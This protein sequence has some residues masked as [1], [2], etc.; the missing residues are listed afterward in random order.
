[1]DQEHENNLSPEEN[2]W[3]D[4]ILPPEDLGEELGPHESVEDAGLVS[5]DA[6][7]DGWDPE[8]KSR[9]TSEPFQDEE[10]RD[11]FGEGDELNAAFA[12]ENAPEEAPEAPAEEPE[13]PEEAPEEPV[14]KGRPRRKKGYGLL[15][16]PHILATF[17]WLAIAIAIGVSLGRVIW[18]CVSD[19]MAFGRSDTELEF[20]VTD[21]DT[22]E[23]VAQKLKD[24]GLIRYPGLFK[25]YADLTHAENKIA[26]GIYKLKTNY[27][28]HAL[29]NGLTPD[30][31]DSAIVTVV[32][33]E[34][35]TCREIFALLEEKGVCTAAELEDYAA[36]GELEDYWF[37]DGLELV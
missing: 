14:K 2:A 12:D 33:P 7:E 29:V 8:A 11:T 22:V 16:I 31:E 28:Y 26:P 24:S 1:M 37:L 10:F 23:T 19:V 25:M 35:Y 9:M 17:V 21:S 32:V 36:N 30:S 20:Q 34:G 3:L 6:P 13:A 5:P 15:G 18:V 4:E 27:D